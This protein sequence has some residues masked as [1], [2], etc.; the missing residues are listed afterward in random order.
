MSNKEK[1][2]S[3]M[4]AAPGTENNKKTDQDSAWKD[5]IEGLFEPFTEFFFLPIYEDI[6]FSKGI[7]ILDTKSTGITPYGNVGKRYADQ[8]VKVYL[9]DGTRACICVFIHVEVQG[10]KEKPGVFPERTYVYNYRTYDKNID[11]GIKVVSIAILTDDDENYRPDEYLVRQW[12]FELRMKI[13]IVK[14]IDYK[15]KK[16]LREKLET[17]DNPM[18]MVVKAQLKSREIKK[19]GD[20]KKSTV[21]WELIRECYAK[22]YTKKEI[23]VL[24]KFIDWLILLPDDLKKQLNTKI[25]KLE[26]DYKMPYVTSWERDAREEGVKRGEKIGKLEAAREFLRNGVDID[27]VVK[28]TGFSREEIVKLAETIH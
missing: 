21:K 23:R 27:I 4:N 28:S 2:K 19:A 7:E 11:K 24:I 22:G 18:A 8:L 26:E 6:D 15:T 10:Y 17:S 3:K 25:S 5:V 1:T 20:N 9:K 16:E 12:G 14:I 13:P